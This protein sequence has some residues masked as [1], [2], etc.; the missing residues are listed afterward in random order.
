M[1]ASGGFTRLE[2]EGLH[3]GVGGNEVEGSL[4]VESIDGVEGGTEMTD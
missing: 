2:K 3:G 1:I 4:M